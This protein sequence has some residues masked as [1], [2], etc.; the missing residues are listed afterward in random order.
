MGP[1]MANLAWLCPIL[2]HSAFSLLPS[3][4]GG[5]RVACGWLLVGLLPRYYIATTSLLPS[6]YI[7]IYGYQ[8]ALGGFVWGCP[9]SH[10]LLYSSA[11]LD[12]S[13]E[14]TTLLLL[15]ARK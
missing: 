8:V 12:H 6:Y 13:Q 4:W 7:V 10:I 9:I 5:F 2:R 11:Y 1:G 15:N 3:H 14:I